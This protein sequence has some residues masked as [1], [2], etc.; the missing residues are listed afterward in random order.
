M[1][2]STTQSIL[3]SENQ[4]I[5]KSLETFIE[6]Y[7]QNI[8]GTIPLEIYTENLGVMEA[9]IKYLKEEKNYNYSEIARKLNRD[10]RTI[11]TGY[12][13]ALQKKK[14][15]F[16]IIN[17]KQNIPLTILTDR[18]KTPLSQIINYLKKRHNMK[19]RQIADLLK[20]DYKTIWAANKRK[21]T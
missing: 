6:V 20:K 16:M 5:L 3:I 21:E 2:L 13:K 1:N 7:R 9:T 14:E 15:G 19:T 17:P 18:T 11:W 4:E 12:K 10:E 8:E